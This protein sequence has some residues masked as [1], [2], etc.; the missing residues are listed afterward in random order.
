MRK[1]LAL[2]LFAQL[3]AC[4]F[5]PLDT[6]TSFMFSLHPP[7][8]T[9]RKVEAQE[10]EK[11]RLVIFA[12]TTSPELD[13]YRIALRTEDNRWDYYAEARWSDF[14][15][16]LV[17]DSV[18][19]TLDESGLFT[20][21]ATGDSGLTG[22]KILKTEIRGFHA[23]Y[24]A[25]HAAPVVKIRMIA[26]LVSRHERR[27]LASFAIRVERRATANSLSAVQAAFSAAFGEAQQ[28][29]VAKLEARGQN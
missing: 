9:E 29:L 6:G 16:M 7:V 8:Q 28:Q 26:S 18:T 15:P 25:G 13:T 19:K 23:E 4:S 12:P 20:S 24:R 14:L 17:Q 2:I 22:D 3:T 21:V 1:T 5:T 11:D 10:A 27:P